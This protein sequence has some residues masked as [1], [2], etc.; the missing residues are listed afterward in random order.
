MS[1]RVGIDFGTSNSGIAF[2]QAGQVHVLPIETLT[3]TPQVIKTIL[4]LTRDQK[5][6]IGQEAVELYYQHNIGRTRNYVKK[7]IGEVE[8]HGGDMF[9]VTD[10]YAF[11]DEASPGRLLQYLKT[12]LRS[13]GY[14]GTRIFDRFYTPTEL[15]SIYLRE[16]KARAEK[17]LHDEIQEVVLGRPVHFA[18]K[19]EL[20]RQAENSLRDAALEA[21]FHRVEFE[22]EPVAAALFYEQNLGK[23]QNTLIFDF[24]GGTLDI[25]IMRLGD[26]KRQTIYGSGGIDIA[27][28]DFDK[29]IIRQRMLPHFGFG[30]VEGNPEVLDMIQS[31]QN[32]MVLPEQ[33]TP[34]NR[35][36]LRQAIQSGLAP[37]QLASLEALIFNDL[38]FSFYREIEDAKIRL[39]QQGA[40]VIQMRAPEMKLWQIYTRL[41]FEKDIQ[42]FARSIYAVILQTMASAGFEPEQI[43]TVVTT[44][45]SSEIPLFKAMLAALFGKDKITTSDSFNSVT[46]GLGIRAGTSR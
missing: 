17:L 7:R 14:G 42:V 10:V 16:I 28:S 33:S 38:A 26:P 20:D 45:G 43:D 11:L 6:Y 39:S 37:V 30:K 29:A 35:R 40:T 34:A 36:R 19:P 13:E 8:Y 27:G 15:V 5:A 12:A 25:T 41:Q 23:P 1:L 2:A 18:H 31:L 3:E 4:Y 44:G 22:L 24:G 21:G 32:W 46:A 9:Y